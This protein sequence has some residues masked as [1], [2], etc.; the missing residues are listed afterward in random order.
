MLR[1]GEWIPSQEVQSEPRRSEL[2]EKWNIV[3]ATGDDGRMRLEGGPDRSKG[4][5]RTTWRIDGERAAER[6]CDEQGRKT[7]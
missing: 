4:A 6:V 1:D 2:N 7:Q 5:W 3:V